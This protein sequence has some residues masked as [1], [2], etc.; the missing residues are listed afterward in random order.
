MI[1]AVVL[2]IFTFPGLIAFLLAAIFLGYLAK[3]IFADSNKRNRHRIVLPPTVY[4]PVKND[5]APAV[6]RRQLIK[7][8]RTSVD[9]QAGILTMPPL[10]SKA[11]S[12][13]NSIIDVTEQTSAVPKIE[14]VPTVGYVHKIE[15]E[16]ELESQAKCDGLTTYAPSV[17]FWKHQYMYSADELQEASQV[18]KSFYFLFRDAFVRGTFYDLDGN[19]NYAFI[20]LF[21]LIASHKAGHSLIGLEQHLANLGRFYPKT[22]SYVRA[23][24]YRQLMKI[25]EYNEAEAVKVKYVGDKQAQTVYR[26]DGGPYTD[27]YSWRFGDR[28]KIHLGLGEDE[29]K[30]LNRLN[31]PANN[32]LDI[33]FCRDQ[34]IRLYLL[35]IKI[36]DDAYRN[37]Q[38]DLKTQFTAIGDVVV[39]KDYRYKLNSQNYKYAIESTFNEIHDFVFR[40]CENAVR[41]QLGHKRKLNTDWVRTN[42][43]YLEL[44]TRLLSKLPEAIAIGATKIKVPDRETEK[45]LNAQNPSR[46]KIDFEALMKMGSWTGSDFMAAVIDLAEL[47]HHNASI[48][49]IFFEASKFAAK[50]DKQ[51]ALELYL[52]YLHHDL[53]SI[54][55]DNRKLT[56]TIQKSLFVKQGQLFEF[57]K[58]IGDLIRTNDLDAALSS[59]AQF[60]VPK[61][62][63]IELSAKEIQT[64]RSKHAGTVE[65]LNEY[66]RD[67]VESSQNITVASETVGEVVTFEIYSKETG[68]NRNE[69]PTAI[70]FLSPVQT[71][72]MTA[73]EKHGLV[74]QFDDVES[75]AKRHGLF[76]NQLID[77]INE[78]CFD[79]IDDV[80]IEEEEEGY[81]VS[82]NYY[83]MVLSQ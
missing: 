57:E 19:S 77:S 60:Y 4:Y 82:D 59:V 49:L 45:V 66:L 17:P 64:T 9:Q 6:P 43:A 15:P 20:L 41:E 50:F 2:F 40:L 8:N 16:S 24:L 21:D 14:A 61:R 29:V 39:R 3:R 38:T 48:E 51:T 71:D 63:H 73:F 34:V 68:E 27:Y 83:R 72:L 10:P 52:H 74:M 37:E 81:T 28:H 30:A 76:R 26:G 12:D 75:F 11:M 69:P 80:L 23:S 67:D 79:V 42:D 46:W 55:F 62:K 58:I 7:I 13:D 33:D 70:G 65:L 18:Q 5:T 35:V 56:K 44:Q 22:G 25:G 78:A 31:N 54:K 47:N 53:R 1:F 32:F 36:L